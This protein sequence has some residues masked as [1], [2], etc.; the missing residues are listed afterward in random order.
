M[1]L[2]DVGVM[3]GDGPT[4]PQMSALNERGR[5]DKGMSSTGPFPACAK[6]DALRLAHSALLILIPREGKSARRPAHRSPRLW[7]RLSA[8]PNC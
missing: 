7:R 8:R 5:V 1:S 3:Y 4:R 6:W 2:P